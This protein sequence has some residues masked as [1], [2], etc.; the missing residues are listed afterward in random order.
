MGGFS[1]FSIGINNFL[2]GASS[3]FLIREA[4][5]GLAHSKNNISTFAFLKLLFV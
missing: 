5:C 1:G 4:G 3:L 2:S